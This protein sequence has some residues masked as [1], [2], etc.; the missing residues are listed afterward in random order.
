MKI[1]CF[2][3]SSRR[4]GI[5]TWPILVIG[6][7]SFLS[8]VVIAQPATSTV[9]VIVF[10]DPASETQHSAVAELSESA[11]GALEE[12]SRRLLPPA[13][14]GWEGGKV[15]FKLKVDPEKPNYFTAKFWGSESSPSRLM[16]HC[17]G[18]QIGYRH[19]GDIDILDFGSENEGGGYPGRFYYNT[20]PLPLEL[21][22]GKREVQFEIRAN[23]P[24][25]GY[26][27]TF[28]KYQKPMTQASRG[29]YRAATHTDGFYAPAA[30][31]KQGAAPRATIRT[32]P[33]P[34]VLDEAKKRVNGALTGMLKSG[35][36][37][38]QM[39]VQFLARAYF[40]KWT[41]AHE[42][43]AAVDQVV[44]GVDELYKRW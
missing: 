16:L 1:A 36:P 24:I 35:R 31:E 3:R 37:L 22:R 23:G 43:Q 13:E 33:G 42:K 41:V 40:V 12:P 30:D 11:K 17:E 8:A 19:L 26:G 28:D 2:R 44:R 20:S 18:K 39:E 29:I 4:G 25:W 34:E 27:Q 21:T 9:D 38:N 10:G 15:A 7:T 6:F 5:G 32:A 14:T